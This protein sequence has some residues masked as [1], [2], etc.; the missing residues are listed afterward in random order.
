MWKHT[1]V[2][3]L[4][5]VVSR[6]PVV[7]SEAY[8]SLSGVPVNAS[9]QG[10]RCTPGNPGLIW[11][12][13][14]AEHDPVNPAVSVKPTLLV[15][16]AGASR[17]TGVQLVRVTGRSSNTACAMIFWALLWIFLLL[18]GVQQGQA[19]VHYVSSTST[20]P[21]APYTNWNTAAVTISSA[22]SVAADG[23]EILVTN[24]WYYVG[25]PQLT[26]TNAI[27]LHSVNGANCTTADCLGTVRAFYIA[28][29]GAVVKGFTIE[30]GRG[31]RGAGAIVDAGLLADCRFTGCS[32]TQSHG[33]AVW[34]A[35]N[36]VVSG[37][38]IDQCTA[39]VSGGGIYSEG[40]VRGCYVSRCQAQNG[41]GIHNNHGLVETSCCVSNRADMEGAGIKSWGGI[42]RGCLLIGNSNSGLGAEGGGLK[43]SSG[44]LS[45]SCTVVGNYST[46]GGGI[47]SAGAT[48]LNCIVYGNAALYGGAEY[49]G[50]LSPVIAYSCLSQPEAGEGNITNNPQFVNAAQGN[51]RLATNSP[52]RDAG[53]NLAWMS[54]AVDLDNG[55]RVINGRVDMGAY[56]F[57]IA[58]VAP[59]G[60]NVPPYDTWAKAATNIQDAVNIISNN[61]LV[62]VSNGV[63]RMA[64]KLLIAKPITVRSVNGRA[65]TA[66]DGG[67]AHG[68]VCI[69]NNA[70]LDGFTV[71]NGYSLSNGA[72]IECTDAV[73]EDCAVVNNTTESSG[74]GVSAVNA[75]LRRCEIRNNVSLNGKG[76]GV[77]FYAFS[78]NYYSEMDSCVVQGNRACVGGGG[79]MCSYGRGSIRNCLVIGN[80]STDQGGG[81]I[82]IYEGGWLLENC[83]ICE[84][85]ARNEPGYRYPGGL[86]DT[87]WFTN[88]VINC[89]VM[90][91]MSGETTGNYVGGAFVHS[92][93]EPLPP[94]PGN[95]S[96][97]PLFANRSKGN[98]RLSLASPCYNAGTNRPWMTGTRDLDGVPRIVHGVADMGAYELSPIHY[99]ATNGA[100]VWPYASWEE[101]ATNIQAAVDAAVAGETV[102]VSNGVY[103]SASEVLVTQ[104]ITIA[105]VNGAGLTILEG[106]GVHRCLNLQTSAVVRGFTLRSGYDPVVGGGAYITGGGVLESS[107]VQ[108]CWAREGAG[109]VYVLSNGALRSCAL[110]GNTTILY[111]AG[112]VYLRYGGSLSHCVIWSN[113]AYGAGGVFCESAGALT[114][115]LIWGNRARDYGGGVVFSGGGVAES[116]TI[117]GNT[118]ATNGGGAWLSSGGTLINC[119]LYGNSAANGSNYFINFGSPTF[120]NCCTAPA[121]GTACVTNAPLFVS[122]NRANFRL[123]EASPCIGAAANRAWM[124][125]GVDLDGSPRLTGSAPDVGAYEFHYTYVATTGASVRPYDTWARATRDLQAAVNVAGSNGYPVLIADGIYT[126]AVGGVVLTNPILVKSVNGAA[127]TFVTGAGSRRGF[128][129]TTN[130]IIEGLTI[131]N[132]YATDMGGGV[133]LDGG[134]LI[135]NCRVVQCSA[136]Y[137]AGGVYATRNAGLEDCLIE[138]NHASLYEGGGVYLTEG[139]MMDRCILSGN[140]ASSGGGLC[141]Q[142]G[143]T[144]NSLIVNNIANTGGGVYLRGSTYGTIESS[145][146]CSNSADTGGGI[147]DEGGGVVRN[148]IVYFN[149]TSNYAVS[150]STWSHCCTVPAIGTSC[151]TSQPQ[152]VGSGDYRLN[153]SSPC[154]N[155]GTNQ[156]WMVTGLDLDR[157]TRLVGPTTDIGAYE[158]GLVHYV[159]LQGSWTSAPPYTSWNTAATN[160]Q[161]ALNVCGHGDVVVVTDGV[162]VS[163]SPIAVTQS[164]WLVS[165]NGAT[166]TAIDGQGVRQCLDVRTNAIISGFTF[167]NGFGTFGGGVYLAGGGQIRDCMFVTNRAERYGGGAFIARTG[168]IERC[169]FIGNTAIS[170]DG[171]AVYFQLGG[172]L[173]NCIV[174]SNSAVKGGGFFFEHNGLARNCLVTHNRARG[175]SQPGWGGGALFYYGGQLKNCTLCDNVALHDGGGMFGGPSGSSVVHN[176]IVYFNSAPNGSN[177]AGMAASCWTNCCTAPSIGINCVSADP[178]FFNRSRG[179][180]RLAWGSPCINA[181]RTEPWMNNAVDLANDL[182][183]W[184][185]SVDIGAY[186]LPIL[187]VAGP[188]KP[189]APYRTWT[190]AARNIPPA[191]S[192]AREHCVIL[193]NDGTYEISSEISLRNSILLKS[194][195]GPAVTRINGRRMTRCLNINGSNVVVEGF[196]ICNGIQ[197]NGNGGGV[198]CLNGG[199]VRG[200]I[201]ENNSG[202]GAMFLG[203]GLIDRCIV[204]G[205]SNSNSCGG[206][207]LLQFGPSIRNSLIYSNYTGHSMGGGGLYVDDAWVDNCTIVGNQAADQGGGISCGS[208][209][210]VRNCIIYHNSAPVGSNYYLSSPTIVFTNCCTAPSNGTACVT[211]DPEFV[212]PGDGDF[213]LALT[214]PCIDAGLDIAVLTNDLAGMTR[215]LDGNRDS[216]AR[217]DIGAYETLN[218]AADTDHDG[219]PDG[220]EFAYFHH[221]T[222]AEREDD[223]DDDRMSNIEEYLAH[224]DPTNRESCLRLLAPPRLSPSG[225]GLVLQWSSDTGVVYRLDRCARVVDGRWH[226]VTNVRGAVFST[227]VTDMTEKITSPLFYRIVIPER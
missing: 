42:V 117:V 187:H 8:G 12:P 182:R 78:T 4:P 127:S 179:N 7:Q 44:A 74:G 49:N 31:D 218:P 199:T 221:P 203:G 56:E 170:N 211:A 214:S 104:S 213:Q 62:L 81:G 88:T 1:A 68:C 166:V 6:V 120:S 67:G 75:V 190:T 28:N 152:F 23:D 164:V 19:A 3:S 41:G 69:L 150:A 65:V 100:H 116:C 201:I 61:Y 202:G 165:V 90:F 27:R 24:G 191:V 158:Q 132:A 223:N 40:V 184:S 91:N 79:I 39:P 163:T 26:V 176:C 110:V 149:S 111:N 139:A 25:H 119:I 160:I 181:G 35:S 16:R 169:H 217:T 177:Y 142:G 206:G 212:N 47:Y 30:H 103:Q 73:V 13:A 159:R 198:F 167:S 185:D 22:L 50:R 101:A 154:I 38:R 53:T 146:I 174:Q 10:R 153:F 92:C 70:L 194:V 63:Y 2:I 224:T 126:T 58:H 46:Y 112:A 59:G 29:T 205:N 115:C 80:S 135:R 33:G 156:S 215:P 136:G 54:G 143:T 155:A 183:V 220:W 131:T 60:G 66:I 37:C 82:E 32:A 83:T 171:G 109:G 151:V 21:V 122:E 118:A 113:A 98:Y 5:A 97:D 144:R 72:G 180:Y 210:R 124:A 84:N 147:Y 121:I 134:A 125:G 64:S 173:L 94:G 51:Y 195:N 196:T 48:T 189:L 227:T 11:E 108:N 57:Q 207:V 145:T 209:S 172:T 148:C 76:G 18:A 168:L 17:T 188:S 95:I 71:T 216:I 87:T 93:T 34:V 225:H 141:D 200:C 99:V 55:V 133:Y 107:V 186:E 157:E 162:H 219:L 129:V 208:R 226:Y 89:I 52:C 86:Y 178:L 20:N 204:R 15:C 114:N 43:I 130:A 77:L 14:E 193:V 175:G 36:G 140:W 105:S 45:E 137:F 138:Q 222:G 85:W 9:Q 128:Y 161:D 192:E 102:L 197:T 96:S 123:S 106:D